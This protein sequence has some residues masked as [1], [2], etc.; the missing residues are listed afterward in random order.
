MRMTKREN[1]VD[2]KK[3]PRKFEVLPQSE[4]ILKLKKN[5]K[6]PK[7]KVNENPNSSR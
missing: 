4:D 5:R 2:D 3:C 1:D 7:E 6:I